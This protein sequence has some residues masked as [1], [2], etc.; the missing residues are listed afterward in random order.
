MYYVSMGQPLAELWEEG[1]MQKLYGTVIP[2]VTPLTEDDRIDIESLER[3]TD[4]CIDNGMDC[5][6]PNGT[7]GEMMY[8]TVKERKEVAECV[9]RHCDHRI[10]VFVHVGA[11]NQADTIEL[12]RHAAEIGAEGIGVVT[13]TYFK[14]SDDGL[15]DYYKAISES[16]PADFPIYIYGIPQNAVNDISTECAERI[17]HECPNIVGIK[18]SFPDMTRLQSFMPIKTASGE[19]FSVLVGPDHLFEAVCAVGGD[20]VISGNAQCIPEHYAAVWKAIKEKDFDRAT[21]VQRETNVLNA[22][23]CKINNIA[24]YKV[25]LKAEGVIRTT[26]MRRPYE[27]L[28]PDQEAALLDELKRLEYRKVRV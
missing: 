13:P 4:H 20:G 11:W 3:L 6:Y 14:I 2:I 23:L 12:A 22:V 1:Y 19:P 17:A 16:V 7:T 21:L 24:A 18:Y 28:K 27:N 5:L 15:V 8:L 9:V 10:P 25:V 26:N